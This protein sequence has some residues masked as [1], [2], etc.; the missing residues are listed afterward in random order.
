MKVVSF[1]DQT[2]VTER[3]TASYG[4]AVAAAV[5]S[6]NGF[7]VG[8]GALL[9]N[10]GAAAL[11][12]FVLPAMR[13]QRAATARFFGHASPLLVFYLFYRECGVMLSRPGVRWRD[14]SLG[15][16]EA[17]LQ[18]VF[19]GL[20]AGAGEALAAAYMSYVP[21]L[22]AAAILVFRGET[23]ARGLETLVRRV[24]FAWA[25]CFAAFVLFPVL[26]P[27][28]L[29]APAQA[30]LFGTGPFSGLALFNQKYGM[31]Y[32]GSFPSAHIAASVIALAALSPRQRLLFLPLVL[33]I[34]VSVIALRYHYRVDVVAGIL[35]GLGTIAF[36]RAFVAFYAVAR[37]PASARRHL[38]AAG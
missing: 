35:V 18:R 21:F 17:S 29:D 19:P 33:S 23:G 3:F 26:G 14:A 11:V 34:F 13:R 15:G 32:G 24:C 9:I 8:L 5:I 7:A 6:A 2:S 30:A 10:V 22:V 36:D 25:A 27:R 12:L 37:D 38:E 16:A 4:V 1:P 28:F 31:L 20:Q